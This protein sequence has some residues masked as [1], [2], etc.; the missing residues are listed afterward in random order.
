MHPGRYLKRRKVSAFSGF[1]YLSKLS[2]FS[3]IISS[4]RLVHFS[5][6]SGDNSSFQSIPFCHSS[7]RPNLALI[8]KADIGRR[9][10]LPGLG[11]FS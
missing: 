2:S 1:S 9:F 7:W 11:S 4:N 8:R 6:I 10:K 5:L 3:F